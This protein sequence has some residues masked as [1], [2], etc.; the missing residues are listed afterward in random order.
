[1]SVV[2]AAI[3]LVLGYALWWVM[4]GWQEA[5]G[6]GWAADFG[7]LCLVILA[8]SAAGKVIERLTG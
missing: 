3:A 6:L 4:P 5:V 8:I 7:Q 1:M 2:F